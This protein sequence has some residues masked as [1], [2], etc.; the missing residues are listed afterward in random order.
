MHE[1]KE[2][3]NKFYIGHDED[4]PLAEITYVPTEPDQLI[5]DHTFVSDELRGT[6]VGKR[7]VKKI[8][9]Y[10]RNENK[11]IVPLCPFVERQI[12]KNSQW[13]DVLN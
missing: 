9:Q 10:A 8:V 7:L 12:N 3:E 6:G 11:R 4:D 5:A 1:I 13:Q 2:G